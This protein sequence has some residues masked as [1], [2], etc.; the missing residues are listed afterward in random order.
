MK[1]NHFFQLYSNIF[2]RIIPC[3]ESTNNSDRLFHY[4]LRIIPF[5]NFVV[6]KKIR[7]SFWI[8][9][10][11]N[12]Y[13]KVRS[14]TKIE[15]DK[16]D[17]IFEGFSIFSHEPIENIPDCVIVIYNQEYKL[18]IVKEDFIENFTIKEIELLRRF[19]FEEVLELFDMKLKGFE[20]QDD[21]CN[22]FHIMP[23]FSRSLPCK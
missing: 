9:N 6:C 14:P 20:I 1:S 13:F 5:S 4:R 22:R 7:K 16:H 3:N 12:L 18:N 2:K 17:Y 23:R 21:S 19:I 10:V 15:F 8:S 11:V